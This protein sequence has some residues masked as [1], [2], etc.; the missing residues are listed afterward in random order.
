MSTQG[1]GVVEDFGVTSDGQRVQLVTIKTENLSGINRP[2]C[3]KVCTFGA[4]IVSCCVPGRNSDGALDMF[5]VVLGY[6]DAESYET[7]PPYLGVIVGRVA[8]RI[9]NAQFTIPGTDKVVRLT[10]NSDDRHCVHGGRKGL[11]RVLWDISE[12]TGQSITLTHISPNDADGFPGTMRIEVK[13]T[14][15]RVVQTVELRIEYHASLVPVPQTACPINLTNHTLWNLAGHSSGPSC[16]AKH[17]VF[18]DAEKYVELE[19][20]ELI[21]TGRL[22]SVEKGTPQ[23]LRNFR[24]V[25]SGINTLGDRNNPG[26]DLYYVFNETTINK[27][28][29][30]VFYAPSGIRLRVHTDQPGAQFYTGHYLDPKIDPVGKHGLPYEASSGLALEVQGWPNACNQ[31]NFPARFLHSGGPAYTQNTT[32]ILDVCDQL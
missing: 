10:S 22:I 6:R 16:L 4:A 5:D 26:Y 8:G 28:R 18:I 9:E 31:P 24:P 2:A 25:F 13:Y 23:D 20:V 1:T 29:A 15:C 14:F 27:P 12:L 7:N 32:Y 21:P 11:S 19:P 17:E 30:A 3:L